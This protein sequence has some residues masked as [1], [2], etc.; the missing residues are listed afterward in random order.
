MDKKFSKIKALLFD[1]DGVMTD[2]S[3]YY[4]SEGKELKRFNVK[5]GLISS[6]LKSQGLIL[7][8]ITGRSSVI[9]KKRFE[10]LKFDF[11]RQGV[12]EKTKALDEFCRMYTVAYDEICYAGDDVNDLG[13]IDLA[14]LSFCPSDAVQV[15][16]ENVDE[17]LCVEGGKGVM[18]CIGDML[19]AERGYK[20]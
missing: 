12:S 1:V 8:I 18:R 19:L 7:G 17:V 4:D 14:G 10:E 2:G 9:V 6:I 16:K 13:I 11:I 20:F 3:I 5:D 15:V